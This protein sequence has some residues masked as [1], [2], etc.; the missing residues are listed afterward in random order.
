MKE[1]KS[2]CHAFYKKR[3]GVGRA[4]KRKAKKRNTEEQSG[5]IIKNRLSKLTKM[6]SILERIAFVIEL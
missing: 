3:A 1:H 5:A 6:R 4:H 2:F